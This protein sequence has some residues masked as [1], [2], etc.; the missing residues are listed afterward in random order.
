MSALKMEEDDP[1]EPLARYPPHVACAIVLGVVSMSSAYSFFM[2]A[3]A[4]PVTPREHREAAA[5]R[6]ASQL[7]PA[8]EG[9]PSRGRSQAIE[10]PGA[11]APTAAAVSVSPSA[12]TGR[13]GGSGWLAGEATVSLRGGEVGAA[14][15]TTAVPPGSGP[16]RVPRSNAPT[17]ATSSAPSSEHPSVPTSSPGS[18]LPS[19][20]GAAV[21]STTIAITA[22][23]EAAGLRLFCFA[24]TP[25]R[26]GDE[27]LMP[28]VRQLF[29]ACDGHAFYT[30]MDAPGSPEGFIKVALPRTKKKRKDSDWLSHMNM[31]GLAPAWEHIFA[32]GIEEMYD[33]IVNAELDHFFVASRARRCIVD[34]LNILRRGS[35]RERR[36]LNGSVMLSWGNVFV[37][38]RKMARQMKQDWGRL[39]APITGKSPGMGCP[40]LTAARANGVGVCEQDMAYPVLPNALHPHAAKYGPDGCSQTK[41]SARG[42]ELPLACWQDFPL[43]DSIQNQQAAFREIALM[44]GIPNLT[45][46]LRHCES[47]GPRLRKKD[48]CKR[49]YRAVGVPVIHNV[50]SPELHK[51]ARE[52]LLP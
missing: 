21:P 23:R 30:D 51:L 34:H 38:N 41:G 39:G 22:E 17:S 2:Q 49:L 46:A 14:R 45:M 37:F 52:L 32:N 15:G 6:F 43:G 47:R 19:A 7:G 8:A 29:S 48:V 4:G 9:P 13:G 24:W 36:S 35:D 31:V 44:R 26:R 50:K 3:P 1:C 40:Q 10:E 33:W 11:H 12:P 42:V 5:S 28:Y 25:R 20:G 18:A 27:L 16:P